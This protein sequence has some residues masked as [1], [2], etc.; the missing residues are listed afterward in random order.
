M[1]PTFCY[2][3]LRETLLGYI[4]PLTVDMV[5]QRTLGAVGA[6][7]ETLE[8]GQIDV[9]VETAM[10]S[11]RMFVAEGKLPDLML[12]LASLVEETESQAVGTAR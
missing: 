2:R 9:V 5:L 1:P 11:L 10:V 8:C 4:S 12:D 6:S 3:R 7:P